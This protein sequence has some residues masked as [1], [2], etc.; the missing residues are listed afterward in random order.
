[1]RAARPR[2]T[3]TMT[4]DGGKTIAGQA[5]R[6]TNMAR[7]P[8]RRNENDQTQ[9]PAPPA[10][11][12][13]TTERQGATPDPPPSLLDPQILQRVG[14]AMRELGFAG[15][16]NPP[17]LVYVGLTSRLLDRPMNLAFVAPSAAGK[18]AAIEAALE[19]MPPEAYHMVRA[20]SPRALI[21]SRESF[22]HRTIIVGEADSLPYD[23]P[24]AAA[25]RSLAADNEMTYEVTERSPVTGRNEAM[26]ITKAGPTGLMTTSTKS[27]GHEMG[28]RMLEVT[29]SDDPEQTR[30]IMRAQ[31]RAVMG[32][33]PNQVDLAPFI[34]AQVWLAAVGVRG[35]YLPFADA[36]AEV[37]PPYGVRAR[38]DFRQLLTCI[39][40]IALLYQCQRSRTPEG[41]VE[42]T[43]DDYR[44]ARTLLSSIFD[45]I[46][47]EGLTPAIRQTV[48]AVP[49]HG[50][51]S[52][53][54]LVSRL[55]LAKSTISYRVSR[56]C[57]RGWLVKLEARHGE[58]ARLVRGEPLPDATTCLPTAEA[59]Q[60]AFE[61]SSRSGGGMGGSIQK[62]KMR[63][64]RATR[65]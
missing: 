32:R 45:S 51:A 7:L 4:R 10:P 1:M 49:T 61:C 28:T 50:E 46:N 13:P 2:A 5:K 30:A 26:R 38:R 22:E 39:R 47:A 54:V 20:C 37:V 64:F 29:L 16:L 14:N 3:N 55:G 18:N 27:L 6:K 48:E 65:K 12:A 17:L 53:S 11:P 9:N 58:P 62:P 44:A 56:A 15:N 36:L 42:A 8:R 40:A 52:E 33:R 59:M 24:A 35:V 57:R 34:D 21:Y 63:V 60:E 41:E 25:I 23:G 31:A 43:L 19:L